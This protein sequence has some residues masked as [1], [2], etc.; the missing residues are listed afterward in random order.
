[1][2]VQQLFQ[3]KISRWRVDAGGQQWLGAPDMPPGW[4]AQ[5]TTAVLHVQQRIS[6]VRLTCATLKGPSTSQLDDF[7][8]PHAPPI[9][10]S[11]LNSAA[12]VSAPAPI[13]PRLPAVPCRPSTCLHVPCGSQHRRSQASPGCACACVLPQ[14]N[15]A[16]EGASLFAKGGHGQRQHP[17]GNIRAHRCP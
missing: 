12:T 5:R 10:T 17:R 3:D 8:Q 9:G 11:L 2:C 13:S 6:D 16:Q 4:C 1:M 14:R 7:P 15:S